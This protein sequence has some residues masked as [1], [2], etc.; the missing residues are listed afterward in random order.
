MDAGSPFRIPGAVVSSAA[1]PEELRSK[2]ESQPYLAAGAKHLFEIG[3]SVLRGESAPELQQLVGTSKRQSQLPPSATLLEQLRELVV[4]R[5]GGRVID[6]LR[7]IQSD[8]DVATITREEWHAGL[9]GLGLEVSYAEAAELYDLADVNRNGRLDFEELQRLLTRA[10]E[11][12]FGQIASTGES[13]DPLE[14]AAAR[15]L[16]VTTGPRVADAAGPEAAV[17]ETLRRSRLA[18]RL[19]VEC[20]APLGESGTRG[21]LPGWA[22]GV[23]LGRGALMA[24][25]RIRLAQPRQCRGGGFAR[26]LAHYAELTRYGVL[27]LTCSAESLRRWAADRAARDEVALVPAGRLFVYFEGKI[28][29]FRRPEP[30]LTCLDGRGW[31]FNPSDGEIYEGELLGGKFDGRGRLT[32]PDGSEYVGEFRAHLK[33]GRGTTTFADGARFVGEYDQ[34]LRHG[35]GR[36]FAA[37]HDPSNGPTPAGARYLV[38]DG[39]WEEGRFVGS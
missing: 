16:F 37:R 21:L 3:S 8:D 20:G 12:R 26:R 5:S 32:L 19:V 27:V 28:V 39:F 4:S 38:A 33:Q 11:A 24:S 14:E 15:A 25:S 1:R 2:S 6:L 30:C 18:S 13:A 29:A 31:C 10:H 17:E 7:S 34:G 36:M 35:P 23:P 22:D 9:C